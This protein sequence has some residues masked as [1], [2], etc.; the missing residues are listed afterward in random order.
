MGWKHPECIGRKSLITEESGCQGTPFMRIPEG[1]CGRRGNNGP[2]DRFG[3]CSLLSS[4]H[5]SDHFLRS[6]L[7]RAAE[8]VY[9]RPLAK[10]SVVVSLHIP[11]SIT[12]ANESQPSLLAHPTRP[13]NALPVSALKW[14]GQ[15]TSPLSQKQRSRDENQFSL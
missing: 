8:K 3:T 1:S 10:G 11:L 5:E 7:L 13:Y 15:E 9:P 6:L 12:H 2:R 4:G 14:T